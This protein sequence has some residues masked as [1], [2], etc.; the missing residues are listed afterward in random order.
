MSNIE[1][2]RESIS[3][4]NS[5]LS[6]TDRS[7]AESRES[8]KDLPFEAVKKRKKKKSP[9]KNESSKKA[10]TRITPEKAPTNFE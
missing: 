7:D 3:D 8:F 5:C 1:N 6:F 2:I 10:D 9:R 4:F